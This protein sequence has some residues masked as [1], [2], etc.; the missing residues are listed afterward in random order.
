MPSMRKILRLSSS[1]GIYGY[2][3]KNGDYTPTPED[4]GLNITIIRVTACIKMPPEQIKLSTNGLCNLI[5]WISNSMILFSLTND[6]SHNQKT[7]CE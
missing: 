2:G 5:I 1:Y 7:V 6:S 4:A 3:G